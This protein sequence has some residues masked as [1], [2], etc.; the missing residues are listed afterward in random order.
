MCIRDRNN[1]KNIYIYIYSLIQVSLPRLF[2]IWFP[3]HST[4]MNEA[5]GKGKKEVRRSRQ[6][7]HHSTI[8]KQMIHSAR[9]S[10]K[11]LEGEKMLQVFQKDKR[12]GDV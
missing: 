12:V 1:V 8:P 3:K 9:T 2:I 6:A 10:A 7:Y 4:S 11:N 5:L